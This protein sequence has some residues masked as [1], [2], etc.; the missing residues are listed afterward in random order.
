MSA[1]FLERRE[2]HERSQLRQSNGD[3][4]NFNSEANKPPSKVVV[5]LLRENCK[6]PFTCAAGRANIRH[7][8][9][10]KEKTSILV[11]F[12]FFFFFFFFFLG[13]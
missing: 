3:C 7:G 2:K 9:L 4:F 6:R 5:M 11:D 13:Q 12:F 8:N 1:S 10:A